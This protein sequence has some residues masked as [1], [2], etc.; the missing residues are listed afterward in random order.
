MRQVEI[1]R[2]YLNSGGSHGRWFYHRTCADHHRIIPLQNPATI[3]APVTPSISLGPRCA[4]DSLRQNTPRDKNKTPIVKCRAP[5]LDI[6]SATF[7]DWVKSRAWVDIPHL[8]NHPFSTELDTR[9]H[10][11]RRPSVTGLQAHPHRVLNGTTS[12]GTATLHR[13]RGWGEKGKSSYRTI[14]ITIRAQLLKELI[15]Y[16]VDKATITICIF[17]KCL[18]RWRIFLIYLKFNKV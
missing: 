11:T 5:I 3:K 15:V 12:R 4:S 10:H 6:T 16:P 14:L 1:F 18:K 7:R 9:P 13:C 17:T 2:K 8:T